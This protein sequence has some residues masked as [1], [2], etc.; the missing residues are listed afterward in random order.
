MGH[1]DPGLFI[2][3]VLTFV[4]LMALLA[5]FAFRPLSVLLQQRED[6]I[7]RSLDE[8][9][10][11]RDEAKEI[12]DTNAAQLARAQDEARKLIE[13]GHRAVVEMRRE[14]DERAREESDALV[15]RA[16][17]EI[18]EEKQRSLDELKSTVA[19]LSVRIARQVIREGL[20]E[21]RHEELADSFIERLKKTHAARQQS[22]T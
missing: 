1:G 19:G 8:A 21:E 16:R 15:A 7:R 14:A 6:A 4:G 20:D 13:D 11:A 12:A 17:E 2:W 10:E 3:S 5:R 9:R 22:R 18:A